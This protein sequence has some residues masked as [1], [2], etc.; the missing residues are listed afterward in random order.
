[1]NRTGVA[2]KPSCAWIPTIAVLSVAVLVS[3]ACA[4]G[5]SGPAPATTPSATVSATPQGPTPDLDG[6][7]KL[8]HL[9]FIV[10]ENRS[11][12]SYFGTYPGA[13]G[14]PQDVC[15]PDPGFDGRC[16]RP[17]HDTGIR[18]GGGPHSYDAAVTDI[19]GG[20]MDG[21]LQA[22]KEQ[23]YTDCAAEGTAKACEGHVGPT[24]QLDVMGHHDRNEIPLY[25]QL[26][27]WGVLQDRMF[28]PTDSW[29]LPAHLFLMSAWS[30]VCSDHNDPMS[31]DSA[32]G[33]PGSPR[34]ELPQYRGDTP[35]AWTDITYLLDE[36]GVSWGYYVS[37]DGTCYLLSCDSLGSGHMTTGYQNPMPGFLTVKEHGTSSNIQPYTKYERAAHSGDL[38]SVSWVIPGIDESDHPGHGTVVDGQRFVAQM[39]NAATQG[40]DWGSTAI[41][42]VW[43]D[44]GGFYDHV[45]PPRIDLNGY[46]IRV[47]GLMVSPYA[48]E[49]YIDT[50]I[51]S[52]DAYLKLI[53]DRFLGGSRLDPKTD[54]RPDPRP[55][56]REEVGQL[57]NLLS[58][59]DFNQ[60]PRQLP[61][62]QPPGESR[63]S[64]Q[65]PTSP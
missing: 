36:Q 23:P 59:F 27:D 50:Q 22:A 35:Y 12:D 5:T 48:R 24:G 31:C 60:A 25:W 47:P 11:F 49:G 7:S 17:Y 61:V 30:A 1:V 15:V 53:E 55:T 32:I 44:W 29:T 21:F 41:F 46:G 34:L 18:D 9:V 57:G 20:K 28:A 58:E 8:D 65:P 6:L 51:L 63:G 56:V 14:I 64:R 43:D 54:G 3:G 26:A 13:D 39:V 4:P 19:H 62:L 40:P 16:Q 52:F 10:M 42:V 45:A 33:R 37:P 2:K 38:P